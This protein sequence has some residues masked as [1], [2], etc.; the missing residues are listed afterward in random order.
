MRFGCAV[1]YPIPKRG[2]F[3]TDCRTAAEEWRQGQMSAFCRHS[4]QLPTA[5]HSYP[6]LTPRPRTSPTALY[7]PVQRE[8]A[9]GCIRTA[10]P[11]N[12]VKSGMADH[13]LSGVSINEIGIRPARYITQGYHVG[14]GYQDRVPPDR[15]CDLWAKCLTC[16]L[17]M[18]RY[19][20]PADGGRQ[21]GKD[22]KEFIP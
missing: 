19:D 22:L 12:R 10:L 5:T 2:L 8:A 20:Y 7:S 15:G 3:Q 14:E 4:S 11:T 21:L 13:Y 9:E 17:P 16:P 1:H 6:R 18:C